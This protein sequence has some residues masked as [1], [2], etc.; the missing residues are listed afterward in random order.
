MIKRLGSGIRKYRRIFNG[1]DLQE[2]NRMVSKWNRVNKYTQG[3]MELPK[4]RQNAKMSC[5]RG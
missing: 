4:G 3:G 1:K 2:K 5:I